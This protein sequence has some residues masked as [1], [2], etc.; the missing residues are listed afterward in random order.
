MHEVQADNAV[1]ARI[2]RMN[3]PAPPQGRICQPYYG[4]DG[5]RGVSLEVERGSIVAMLGANGG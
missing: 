4:Q 1:I 2:W 5:G 3:A